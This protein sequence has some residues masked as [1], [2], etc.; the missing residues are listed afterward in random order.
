[1]EDKRYNFRKYSRKYSIGDIFKDLLLVI[2]SLK[3]DSQDS[4]DKKEEFFLELDKMI[5]KIA[6]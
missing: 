3:E 6:E 2:E 5:P 1:M 4:Y